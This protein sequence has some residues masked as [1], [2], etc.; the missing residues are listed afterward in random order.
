[1]A[2][3]VYRHVFFNLTYIFLYIYILRKFFYINVFLLTYRFFIVEFSKPTRKRF[4]IN[5][6][7][8]SF[9]IS[10]TKVILH[11][12]IKLLS[13]VESGIS[14]TMK[15]VFIYFF[16]IKTVVLESTRKKTRAIISRGF[17]YYGVVN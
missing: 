17:I 1:M 10:R 16:I 5:F 9:K 8:C 6:Y 2:L 3:F 15:H 11:L 4:Y 13:P 14:K 12:P 7:N